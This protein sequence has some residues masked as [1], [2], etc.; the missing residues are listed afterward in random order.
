M[1]DLTHVA[2]STE[3]TEVDAPAGVEVREEV[4]Q[5]YDDQLSRAHEFIKDRINRLEPRD[6]ERLAA[7]LI[8]PPSRLRFSIS[9]SWR[10]S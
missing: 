4:V 7:A 2:T 8:A 5:I 6:M 1:R 9:M 3:R 10:S